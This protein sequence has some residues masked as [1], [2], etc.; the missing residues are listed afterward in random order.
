MQCKFRVGLILF[1]TCFLTPESSLPFHVS[2][3]R[4]LILIAY[5]YQHSTIIILNNNVLRSYS[6]CAHLKLEILCL[7]DQF[8]NVRPRDL[9]E[10]REKREQDNI[11]THSKGE[12]IWMWR[13]GPLKRELF[14][15]NML[16]FA[17]KHMT[18]TARDIVANC[19]QIHF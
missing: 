10:K 2:H 13:G 18:K 14:L 17:T 19:V 9:H 6:H 8:P 1:T 3:V 16:S 15:L 4:L 5:N 7:P 12:P 11:C